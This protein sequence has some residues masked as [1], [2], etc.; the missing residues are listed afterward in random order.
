MCGTS[1]VHKGTDRGRIQIGLHVNGD[2]D[3][4]AKEINR[5]PVL[6]NRTKKICVAG[7][8][9]VCAIIGRSARCPRVRA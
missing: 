8:E 9:G 4:G 2:N 1:Y 6:V 3:H 5:W 7:D